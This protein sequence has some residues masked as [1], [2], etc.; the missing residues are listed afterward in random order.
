MTER[1]SPSYQRTDCFGIE[2][3]T[4]GGEPDGPRYVVV[5]GELEELLN[6]DRTRHVVRWQVVVLGDAIEGYISSVL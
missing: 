2:C 1:I 5:V 3:A 4:Q 6:T